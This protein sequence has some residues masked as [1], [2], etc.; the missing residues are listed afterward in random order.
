MGAYTQLS[1]SL[2]K[3]GSF[4][5]VPLTRVTWY[6]TWERARALI[7]FFFFDITAWA[8][9]RVGWPVLGGQ[10][11]RRKRAPALQSGPNQTLR[12]MC[13]ISTA[14]TR[15]ANGAHGPRSQASPAACVR[16]SNPNG[17]GSER[18]RA[19]AAVQRARGR[20]REKLMRHR[21]RGR[22]GSAADV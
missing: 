15:G 10:A 20:A 6:S 12:H 14:P 19:A 11:C 7:A 22:G 17:T 16:G 3:P 8:A 9:D 5:W 18:P 21:S 1:G 4:Q 2:G 13:H